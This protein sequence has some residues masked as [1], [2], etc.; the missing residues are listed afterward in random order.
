MSIALTAFLFTISK[1]PSVALHYLALSPFT[2]AAVRRRLRYSYGCIAIIDILLTQYTSF[3]AA[4]YPT[5]CILT[6]Y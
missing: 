4:P 5:R 2:S 1:L 6:K 3:S